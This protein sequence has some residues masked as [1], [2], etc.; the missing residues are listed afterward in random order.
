[1][2]AHVDGA[3]G[4]HGQPRTLELRQVGALPGGL[5]GKAV[6]SGAASCSMPSYQ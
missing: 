4:R 1:M 2:T 6:W 3:G 5:Q